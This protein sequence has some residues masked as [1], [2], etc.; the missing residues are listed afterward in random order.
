MAGGTTFHFVTGGVDAAL[1]Q[2]FD[3][4]RGADVRLGGGVS[5]IRQCL[6]ARLIDELHLVIVPVLLGSGESLFA[7]LDA[8]AAGYE[9]IEH[10][11]SNAVMHVRLARRR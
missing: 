6:Q 10:T 11:C 8:V 5:T 1:S 4:A 9:C 2:A 7:G 3:A